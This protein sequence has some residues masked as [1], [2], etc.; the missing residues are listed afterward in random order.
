MNIYFFKLFVVILS[1]INSI[2]IS[3][4]AL[5]KINLIILIKFKFKNTYIQVFNENKFKISNIMKKISIK[6]NK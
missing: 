2:L 1:Q 3:R 4:M 5:F 6:I